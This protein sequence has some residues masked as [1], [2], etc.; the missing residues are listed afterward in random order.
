[1]GEMFCLLLIIISL[2][3][4]YL[5][6]TF[7]VLINCVAHYNPA[8]DIIY[9]LGWVNISP[10]VWHQAIILNLQ[11]LSPHDQAFLGVAPSKTTKLYICI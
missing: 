1:M 2:I 9:H 5:S 10:I 7:L 6:L 11:Q 4:C 3:Y 8:N